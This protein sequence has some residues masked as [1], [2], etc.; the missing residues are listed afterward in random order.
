MP[1]PF[2]T[3]YAGYNVLDKWDSPSWDDITRE[4]VAKRLHE[5]PQREFLTQDEWET[6]EAVCA[7]LIPQPDRPEHPVPIVPF[8]DRKLRENQGDGYRYE[9]MPDLRRGWRMGIAGIEKEA[10]RRHKR[11]FPELQPEQQDE[12]LRAIQT[13]E[14]TEDPW[15]ELPARRFFSE[16]LLK[17]VVRI[18]Y[19]HPAAWSEVGFGGP[20]SPRGYVRKEM[21]THDAWEAEEAW[22]PAVAH[23]EM[24]EGS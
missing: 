9:N 11:R 21:G 5:V 1:E 8:I 18:Y 14:V 12:I 23:E 17:T 13:E 20:A 10:D 7:R 19:A 2:S 24:R 3:P 16:I 6:L 15:H 4:V 22:N